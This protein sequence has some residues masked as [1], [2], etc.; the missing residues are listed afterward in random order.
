MSTRAR[1]T[2][3]GTKTEVIIVKI[4]TS[5]FRVDPKDKADL[6]ARASDIE[7]LYGSKKKYHKA[8]RKN[9]KKLSSLQRLHYA[10]GHYALLLIFQGIDTAGKDADGVEVGAGIHRDFIGLAVGPI[11]ITFAGFFTEV[12]RFV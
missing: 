4:K 1:P 9:V 5:A 11:I 8:L 12:M 10:S 2:A 7:P 3:R 6:T